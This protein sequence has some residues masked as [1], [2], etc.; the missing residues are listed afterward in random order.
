VSRE[1]HEA[2]DPLGA[3]LD[4]GFE[5]RSEA[6]LA[7]EARAPGGEGGHGTARIVSR[8]TDT[9]E[10]E[11]ELDVPGALVVTEAFDEGWRAEVDGRAAEVVRANGLF[12]GVRLGAGHHRV[13]F[14]YRPAAA[15]AGAA[16]SGLGLVAAIALG[17]TQRRG[18]RD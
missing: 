10:V 13:R 11:A 2:G 3:L 1:R 14:R 7:G 12:R 6:V 16:I 15:L 4:P 18:E 17:V 8:T 5:P 9:L